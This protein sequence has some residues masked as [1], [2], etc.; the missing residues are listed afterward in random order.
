[1]IIQIVFCPPISNTIE[2]IETYDLFSNWNSR[3]TH[4]AT[5]ELLEN[6]PESLLFPV[7]THLIVT[8]IS[9]IIG[10]AQQPLGVGSPSKLH[11]VILPSSSPSGQSGTPSHNLS[12]NMGRV[13]PNLSADKQL[14]TGFEGFNGSHLSYL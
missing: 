5:T 8:P 1:M 7:K 3:A 2:C 13:N 14:V 4:N 10:N 6:W 12:R 11:S 9:S